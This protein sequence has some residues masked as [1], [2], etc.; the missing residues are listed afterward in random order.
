MT[1]CVEMC[2]P[3]YYQDE[4]ENYPRCYYDDPCY[5]APCEQSDI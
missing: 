2:C 3:Y 1:E 5:P 4:G